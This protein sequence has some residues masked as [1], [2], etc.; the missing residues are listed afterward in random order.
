MQVLEKKKKMFIEEL[1]FK[2]ICDEL[3]R[4]KKKFEESWRQ[5]LSPEEVWVKLINRSY[6]NTYIMM[7]SKLWRYLIKN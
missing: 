4:R 5:W 3:D 7:I 1:S 6:Y 2:E